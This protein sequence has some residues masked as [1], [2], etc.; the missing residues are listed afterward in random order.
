MLRFDGVFSIENRL[1]DFVVH[2]AAHVFHGS[3]AI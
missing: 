2:E 1:D 3:G